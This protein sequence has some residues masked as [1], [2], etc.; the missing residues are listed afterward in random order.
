V[1]VLVEQLQGDFDKPFAFFGHSFGSLIAFELARALRKRNLPQPVHLFASAFPD[2]RTPSKSLNVILKQLQDININ[3]FDSHQPSFMA[4]LSDETLGQLSAIFNENG[5]DEYGDHLLNKEITKVL[6]PIFSG[7]MGIV[8]SY[9][10]YEDGPLDMPITVFAGKRDTWVSYSDHLSW[11]DHTR[12]KCD[13]HAFDSGHLFIK[14]N[15]I[16]MEVLRKI[17]EALLTG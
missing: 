1:D 6:L 5:I 17:N 11:G 13:I 16:R 2:P 9:Q 4:S 10:Y 14:E 15:D 12:R 7:D 8:K 3:L